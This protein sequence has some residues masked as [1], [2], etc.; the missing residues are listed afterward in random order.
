MTD[1]VKPLTDDTY[2]LLIYEMIPEAIHIYLFNPSL[3]D[4]ALDCNASE[5]IKFAGQYR[6]SVD[7]DDLS[8]EEW[9]WL[10]ATMEELDRRGRKQ[11]SDKAVQYYGPL[12]IIT[13]GFIL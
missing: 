13:C 6:N 5:F 4:G 3:N 9:D 11:P 1:A 10:T 8:D 7:A 2:V 12:V